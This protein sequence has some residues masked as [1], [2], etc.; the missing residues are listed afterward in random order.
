MATTHDMRYENQES[1]RSSWSWLLP[2]AILVLGGLALASYL[3]NR[4]NTTSNSLN[5]GANTTPSALDSSGYT[6]Q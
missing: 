4:Y 2:L 3:A 5:S 6:A 1:R